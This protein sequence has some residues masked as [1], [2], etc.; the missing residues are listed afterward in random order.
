MPG[1]FGAG[2]PTRLAVTGGSAD[3]HRGQE[4]RNDP[5]SALRGSVAVEHQPPTIRGDP[6]G[7][8]SCA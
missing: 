7:T 6:Q 2:T 4:R 8:P 5:L 1:V 3:P